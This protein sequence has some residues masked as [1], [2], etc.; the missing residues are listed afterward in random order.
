MGL[1]IQHRGKREV[2]NILDILHI[3][4]NK[5]TNITRT[6][7]IS[8]LR[9]QQ[10]LVFNGAGGCVKD[11]AKEMKLQPQNCCRGGRFGRYSFSLGL[12]KKRGE[13]E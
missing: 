6:T 2:N 5:N 4:C 13:G 8:R 3:N 7:H 10:Q 9:L 1:F 12:K 11:S